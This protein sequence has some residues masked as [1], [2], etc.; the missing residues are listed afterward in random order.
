MILGFTGTRRGLT[1]AQLA[2]L[3]SVI[4]A[5]P[6][7]VLHGGAIGADEQFD[8]WL[9]Q[10]GMNPQHIH[11]LPCEAERE[12]FWI[13]R[14]YVELTVH[15]HPLHL[16]KVYATQKALVRNELIAREC[17]HLLA[18]PAG[19]TEELRS[20]T[21]ATVRYARKAGRALTILWPD[22]S[23]TEEKR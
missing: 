23:V 6:D 4:A 12:R 11:V 10:H 8:R 1:P 17:D 16:R 2:A 20:G 22:G 19:M 15:P 18:C 14:Q 5:L 21:W 9:L 7:R 13:E 3:P